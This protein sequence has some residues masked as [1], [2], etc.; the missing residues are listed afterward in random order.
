MSLGESGIE[1]FSLAD[2]DAPV[3][4]A[5]F[6]TGYWTFG[7][8]GDATKLFIADSY[9]GIMIVENDAGFS[10]VDRPPSPVAGRLWN[11]PN[12]FNPQTTVSFDLP[13]RQAVSLDILDL[14]GHMVRNLADRSFPRGE[15]RVVWDGRGN[16]GKFLPSGVY[17]SRLQTADYT[18]SRKVT[19]V[20]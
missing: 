18:L 2:P 5:G 11:H 17:L 15:N 14:S 1:T 12:P 8:S 4:D 16:D 13:M 9:D 20:R 7:L 3:L 10:G 19:L 6:E